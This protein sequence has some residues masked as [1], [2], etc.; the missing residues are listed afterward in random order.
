H[1]ATLAS[2]GFGVLWQQ[3]DTLSA[4]LDWGIPLTH[5]NRADNTW[6]EHGLHFSIIFN[7]F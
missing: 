4:R 6:Q 3:G 5:N 7:P 2:V 1:P